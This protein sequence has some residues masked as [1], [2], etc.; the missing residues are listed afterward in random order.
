[1][2]HPDGGL[3]R[4][5]DVHRHPGVGLLLPLLL[6]Q[7]WGSLGQLQQ[8]LEHRYMYFRC[9]SF[10]CF[11]QWL[12]F[13]RSRVLRGVGSNQRLVQL[14]S[15]SKRNDTCYRILGVSGPHAAL[16]L[17]ISSSL[18]VLLLPNIFIW[19]IYSRKKMFSFKRLYKVSM[20]FLFYFCFIPEASAGYFSGNWG[21]RF[22]KMGAGFVSASGLGRLLLLCL[23]G[24][25]IHWKGKLIQFTLNYT[26]FG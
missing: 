11:S 17:I 8:H 3:V 4:V 7:C 5:C 13:C 15:A 16:A 26:I 12:W 23:E 1:M 21:N 25:E 19:V 20:L 24:S 2:C 6:L 10:V 9:S 14:D 18:F 22:L